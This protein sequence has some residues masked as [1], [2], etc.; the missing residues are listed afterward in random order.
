MWENIDF[1]LCIKIFMN[2]HNSIVRAEQQYMSIEIISI[3]FA[4]EQ[5]LL[6]YKIIV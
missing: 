6:K 1:I 4:R 3:E 5:M 2:F